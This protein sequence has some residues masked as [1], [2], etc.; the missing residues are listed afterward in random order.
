MRV[1]EPAL[2]KTQQA[3][4]S[5]SSKMR[6]DQAAQH[7]GIPLSTLYALVHQRRVPHYRYGPRFVV[8]DTAELDEWMNGRKVA[9]E[10]V[11]TG[12]HSIP[13]PPASPTRR[14]TRVRPARGP[15]PFG[16]P[17]TYARAHDPELSALLAARVAAIQVYATSIGREARHFVFT[18]RLR[19]ASDEEILKDL[20]RAF[21]VMKHTRVFRSIPAAVWAFADHDRPHLHVAAVIPPGTTIR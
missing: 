13:S 20:V 4:S 10:Q 9:A 3:P 6:Y 16:G 14:R 2:M 19:R 21:A 8:F 18:S 7:L 12:L 15:S 5:P 11:V 17:R 1:R